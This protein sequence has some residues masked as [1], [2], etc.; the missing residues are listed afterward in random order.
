[1]ITVY[2]PCKNKNVNLGTTYHQ[3]CRY[4]IM[5]KQDLT[6]PLNLFC[7]HLVK[8]IKQWLAEGDRMILFMDHNEHVIN[9]ALGKALADKEGLDL[10]EAIVQHTKTSPSAIFFRGSKPIDRLWISSD[11]D[12][13]NACIMPFGYGIG[14]HR[15]FILN[16]PIES[17][18]GVNPVK[19]VWPAGQHS[20]SPLPGCSKSYIESLESNIIKHCLL[21]QLHDVHTSVYSVKERAR[22]VIII[23]EE[24]KA[25]MRRAEKIYRK[26]KCCRIPFSPE[27]AIWIRCVQV[28]HSLIC[29]HKERIKNCR[30]LKKA[31][32]R[33][34]IPN[35][36]NMSIQ[37]TTH[38]LEAYKRKCVFYQEQGKWFRPKHLKHWK[39]IA[40]D[41]EDKE[42]FNKISAIIQQEQQCNFCCKLNYMT[43]KKKMHSATSI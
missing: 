38:R 30:N 34:N 33:Y 15:A 36:L 17:L 23:D 35:P 41:Q 4:F 11:L 37:E 31:A 3:Q 40:Q 42:A 24:G 19:I 32:W 39:Q 10:W 16:V 9:R 25:Y 18:V 6:C 8:Q 14:N 13:S 2:N 28:Y 27:A 43:G 29:C 22:K 7:K 1:M 12:I 5:K 26:I 20:N 21:E